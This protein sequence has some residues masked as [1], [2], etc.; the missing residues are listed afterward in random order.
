[1]GLIQWAEI[2]AGE[3]IYHIIGLK[4]ITINCK[5]HLQLHCKINKINCKFQMSVKK[6]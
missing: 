1:M 4:K 3:D 6:R 2:A 5:N